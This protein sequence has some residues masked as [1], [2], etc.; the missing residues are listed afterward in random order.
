MFAA[1]DFYESV[2]KNYGYQRANL[3]ASVAFQ[4]S[5]GAYPDLVQD[6]GERLNGGD[7]KRVTHNDTHQNIDEVL[8]PGYT[9]IPL[10]NQLITT[11]IKFRLEYF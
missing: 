4:A 5:Y 2:R 3:T 10:Y 7:Q 8:N 11:P 9:D 6:S 1:D